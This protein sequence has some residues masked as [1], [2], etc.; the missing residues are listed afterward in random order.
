VTP[1][2]RVPPRTASGHAPA[3]S[4][5]RVLV[6]GLVCGAGGL[7]VA[8]FLRVIVANT[9]VR[10]NSYTPFWFTVLLA[11]FGFVAGMGLESV[12]QL[13]RSSPEPEYHRHR[14]LRQPP[15]L[16]RGAT[17]DQPAP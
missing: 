11:G 1:T 8:L 16:R 3:F 6:A 15:E 2:R 7:A 12:R 14:S 10:V 17:D 5:G 13:Q 9:T 4:G